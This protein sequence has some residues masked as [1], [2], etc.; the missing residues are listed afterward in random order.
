MRASVAD[1]RKFALN[2][3]LDMLNVLIILN[4]LHAKLLYCCVRPISHVTRRASYALVEIN[5]FHD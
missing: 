2:V 4:P 5:D 3:T 1:L